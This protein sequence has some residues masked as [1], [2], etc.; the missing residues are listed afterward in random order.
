MS[1]EC[2]KQPIVQMADYVVT[3]QADLAFAQLCREL[4]HP[5]QIGFLGTDA[6]VLGANLIACLLEQRPQGN[7][8]TTSAKRCR[9]SVIGFRGRCGSHT[10]GYGTLSGSAMAAVLHHPSELHLS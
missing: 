4:I 7:A 9:V 10:C 3:G 2:D 5:M 1:Y 8:F 6:V